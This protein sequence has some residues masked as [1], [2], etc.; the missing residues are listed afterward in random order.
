MPQGHLQGRAVVIGS[1]W[2]RDLPAILSSVPDISFYSGWEYRSRSSGGFDNLFGIVCHHTA[3]STSFGFESYCKQ[4]WTTHPS[5]PVANIN[6]GRAGEIKVG[7]AG[8]SNHAGVGG[9]RTMSKGTVPRDSGNRY[10]I[11]IEALNTGVGEPWPDVQQE[12]YLALVTAL[13]DGYGFNV[14]TDEVSHHEWTPGRKIDPAGPSRF[15]SINKSGTWDMNVFRG[16]LGGVIVTPPPVV[17]PP[18]TQPT[19]WWDPLMQQLPTLRQGSSGIAVKKMQHLIA[20]A[21]FMNEANT[22]NY[23]G[24][25]GSGTATALKNFQKAAGIAQD[26][27]CGPITWG[28]LMHTIDGIPTIVKGNSGADVKRMQH[29]LAACGFMNEA[30]TGNYDG[31]WG[32]GTE[33]AKITFDN[34]S[35]LTPSPPTDCG[36]G[37]WT[38]LLT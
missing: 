36:K 9:P 32:N 30:N 23:D 15:G 21:G 22:S 34:A 17:T 2:L 10:L 13:C 31:Q 7:C 1:I 8:A 24:K 18:P 11:G 5:K 25:F 28:A 29:L 27:V 26:A 37:S 20:A 16:A 4:A 35:G 12:R 3:T 19:N 14:S 6:L 38:A 33:S